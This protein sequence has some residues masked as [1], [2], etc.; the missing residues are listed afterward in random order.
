MG[1]PHLCKRLPLAVTIMLSSIEPSCS[2]KHRRWSWRPWPHSPGA[3]PRSRSAV[4][5]T[6]MGMVEDR[7]NDGDGVGDFSYGVCRILEMGKWRENDIWTISW[8]H[9]IRWQPYWIDLSRGWGLAWCWKLPKRAWL[10]VAG[11]WC[12]VIC[13]GWL[14]STILC[15]NLA[16]SGCA[17]PSFKN[18]NWA[19]VPQI[20][21]SQSLGVSNLP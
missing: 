21:L 10:L 6:G 8:G 9:L 2:R 11:L 13:D 16:G 19:G 5:A 7:K 1:F 3:K 18:V 15:W 14:C 4:A 17:L 12:T 20:K